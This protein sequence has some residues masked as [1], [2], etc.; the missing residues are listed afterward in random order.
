MNT[1]LI[2]VTFTG[3]AYLVYSTASE[4]DCIASIDPNSPTVRTITGANVKNCG[5]KVFCL[6]IHLAYLFQYF[7]L[8]TWRLEPITNILCTA[9]CSALQK[10]TLLT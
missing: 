4:L 1:D 7:Q 6:D 2:N 8:Y 3:E 10:P 9:A 5:L